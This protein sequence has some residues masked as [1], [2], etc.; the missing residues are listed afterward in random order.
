MGLSGRSFKAQ[1]RDADKRNV[2][3]VVII[4]EDEISEETLVLKNM[5]TGE[6]TPL[7][8]EELISFLSRG[9]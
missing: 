1:F 3:L 8:Q 9:E 4:G 2:K 5:K 7:K 6:Q